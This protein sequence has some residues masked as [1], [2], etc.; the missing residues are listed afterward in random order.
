MFPLLHSFWQKTQQPVWLPTLKWTRLN[1]TLDL[2]LVVLGQNAACFETIWQIKLNISLNSYK[3]KWIF[4]Y[5]LQTTE[6]ELNFQWEHAC[7]DLKFANHTKR[8][9][10]T[11]NLYKTAPTQVCAIA[12]FITAFLPIISMYYY[13][14]KWKNQAKSTKKASKRHSQMLSGHLQTQHCRRRAAPSPQH[15]RGQ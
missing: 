12:A 14:F 13:Y 15:C 3:N 5:Y 4:F 8:C 7:L 2:S 9:S 11:H 10:I 1:T 6:V